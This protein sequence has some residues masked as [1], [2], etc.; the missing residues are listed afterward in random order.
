MEFLAVGHPADNDL[1]YSESFV[2]L[3]KVTDS[4]YLTFLLWLALSISKS[5][6]RISSIIRRDFFPPKTNSKIF[7]IV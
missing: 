5:I 3:Q 2:S 4:G 6:Y 7:G 1:R